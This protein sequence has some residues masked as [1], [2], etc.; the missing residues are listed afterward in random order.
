MDESTT[1]PRDEPVLVEDQ[2]V[3]SVTTRH[4]RC[5]L[6][7]RGTDIIKA[8]RQPVWLNGGLVRVID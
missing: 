8:R 5:V 6:L 2:K 4:A 1:K 7:M 3:L